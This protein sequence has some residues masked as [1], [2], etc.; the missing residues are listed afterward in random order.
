MEKPDQLDRIVGWLNISMAILMILIPI[1]I[2]AYT[3]YQTGQERA[4]KRLEL[5]REIQAQERAAKEDF[6]SLVSAV[7]VLEARLDKITTVSPE[8]QVAA[9]LDV[10]RTGVVTLRD[11][12]AAIERAIRGDPERLLSLPMLRRDVTSLTSTYKEDFAALRGEVDR[13]YTMGQWLIGLF[14]LVGLTL[15]GW[16]IRNMRRGGGAD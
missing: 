3:S 14:V 7:N 16:A 1:A 8:Q 13:I 12:I 6:V 2:V 4:I 5:E 15:G 10:I 11:K 9:Q